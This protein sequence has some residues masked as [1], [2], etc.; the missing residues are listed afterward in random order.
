MKKLKRVIK[1]CFQAKYVC[2]T[3]KSKAAQRAAIL[4]NALVFQKFSRYQK[5]PKMFQKQ[6]KNQKTYEKLIKTR[7]NKRKIPKDTQ[8]VPKTAEKSKKQ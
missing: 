5:I 8:N 6:Q 4:V 1:V 2:G 7:K 3:K